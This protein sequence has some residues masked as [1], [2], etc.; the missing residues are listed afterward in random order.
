MKKWICDDGSAALEIEAE[1]SRE[2]AEEYVAGG[3]Y[4]VDETQ[5]VDVRVWPACLGEE[6]DPDDYLEVVQEHTI[7]VEPTEPDCTADRDGHEWSEAAYK[8]VSRRPAGVSH[9]GGWRGR[10]LCPHCGAVR[11]LDTWAT[12]M[13]TGEQG[14][15]LVRYEDPKTLD[16]EDEEGDQSTV[17]EEYRKWVERLVEE[18]A[19]QAVAEMTYEDR[20]EA[21]YHP[22]RW[23]E[24]W[25]EGLSAQPI[26]EDRDSTV[27][28]GEH[29]DAVRDEILDRPAIRC[30]G[31]MMG[32][33]LY[34]YRQKKS[35]G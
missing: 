30:F 23:G 11:Y 28:A 17:G 18:Y 25:Q 6:I 12:R 15:D 20:A 9:G 31:A 8:R 14:L 22:K 26:Y 5:W 32:D 21:Y 10:E 29:W 35:H 2:A 19:A 7:T 3:D 34:R 4:Y 33:A 27:L 1:S 24:G 16:C 13:D